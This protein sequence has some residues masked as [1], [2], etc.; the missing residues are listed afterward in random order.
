MHLWGQG[1][2][3]SFLVLVGKTSGLLQDHLR[4]VSLLGGL[5]YR[6]AH[7]N[8]RLEGALGP[9]VNLM[10]QPWCQWDWLDAHSR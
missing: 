6:A 7:R 5:S 10:E 8:G 4:W 3:G 1:G 9:V 2:R